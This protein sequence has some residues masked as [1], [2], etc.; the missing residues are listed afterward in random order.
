SYYVLSKKAGY[1]YGLYASSYVLLPNLVTAI[2]LFYGGQLVM[3]GQ[4]TGGKVVSFM[5]YLTSLS[6]GFNDM[7]SIFSSM[8][9]A[10]GAADKV[11]ELIKR[12][13]K[14]ATPSPSP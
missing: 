7:A 12:E 8:T 5:I 11:F 4:I 2:V 9:Q 6:D 14:G 3:E 10:V 1:A 13:P